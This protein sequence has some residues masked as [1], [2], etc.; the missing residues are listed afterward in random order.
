MSD[1]KTTTALALPTAFE[2]ANLDQALVLANKLAD[3]NLIPT[4]LK[5]RPSDVLVVLM[6]GREMGLGPMQSLRGMHVIEGRPS[7]SAE[8]MVAQCLKRPDACEFFTLLE[9][10][11]KV[12]TYEAKRRGAKPVKLSYRIE[13][14]QRAGLVGKE[15]WKRHTEAMLRARASSALARAVFPDLVGGIYCD[16]EEDE[17]VQ[18]APPPIRD[19]NPQPAQQ[20]RAA[21]QDPPPTD[22]EI[23]PAEESQ[24]EAI[25]DILSEIAL[26]T[27]EEDL[28][29]QVPRIQKLDAAGQEAVRPHYKEAVKALKTPAPAGTNGSGEPPPV[30]EREPGSEG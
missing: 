2:P 6:A 15:N 7:M 10:T 22:A 28:R 8:L 14:A 4:P 23:L 21:R 20:P 1:T 29:R 19:V 17:I 26:A 30:D 18:A 13:Q 3:S 9:T 24:E 12:A 16:E 27:T 25:K 5:K 11:D